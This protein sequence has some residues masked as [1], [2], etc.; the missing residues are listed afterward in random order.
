MSAKATSLPL[1]Q[2]V[3]RKKFDEAVAQYRDNEGS[4]LAQGCWLLSAQFPKALFAFVHPQ[5]RPNGLI[6][7]AELDFSNFDLWPISVRFVEPFKRQPYTP[8]TMPTMLIRSQP[9]GPAPLIQFH[10]EEDTPFLCLQGVREYHS[11]P[12]HTGDD[13][14]LH[15]GKGEGTLPHLLSVLIEYGV[16]AIRAYHFGINIT[17]NGFQVEQRP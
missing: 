14:L 15:R 13:W 3:A 17:I 10:S 9:G 4:Y 8:K 1:D 2:E 12:A 7:G 11:H 5:L 6:F 16:N